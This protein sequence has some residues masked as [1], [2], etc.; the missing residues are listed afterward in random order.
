MI[1]ASDMAA[2]SES[3]KPVWLRTVE[4]TRII[5]IAIT[6]TTMNTI[7]EVLMIFNPTGRRAFSVFD[8]ECFF[9]RQ[10]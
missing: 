10:H 9:P 5:D 1:P 3:D 2:L 8:M 7:M 4:N 6:T